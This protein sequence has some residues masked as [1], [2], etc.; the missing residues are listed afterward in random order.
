MG[1]PRSA[2][3][4]LTLFT[5]SMKTETLVV[6]V[7][8]HDCSLAEKMNIQTDAVIGN[9]ADYTAEEI[10]WHNGSKITFVTDSERGVGKNR[11]K[12]LSRATAD[13]CILADDDMRFVDGY[14]GLAGEAFSH[15]PDADIIVF[16]LIEKNPRRYINQTYFPVGYNNYARYGAARIAIRRKSV[17]AANISFSLLF[18]GGARYSSG[19]D[20]IFLHQCLKNGLKIMAAP[21]AL[22]EI[23]QTAQSTWF[24]GYHEKFF[25]DKGAL[26]ACLH[27]RL[28]WLYCARYLIKYRKKYLSDISLSAAWKAMVRGIGDYFDIQSEDRT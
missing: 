13:I 22:A 4:S 23:D 19:E 3:L 25:S 5:D 8:R 21:I 1:E 6:T 10:F 26:Y 24:T 16:N 11:N 17:Q 20:T 7:D 15:C 14:P 9:Q 28:A 12:V 18:G 27:G 2:G